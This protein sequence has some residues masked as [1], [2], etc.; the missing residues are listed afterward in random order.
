MTKRFAL[1]ALAGTLLAGAV[2]TSALAAA[3]TNTS[4]P[5]IAGTQEQGRTLTAR[6]GIWTNSPTSFSYQW[7]RCTAAGLNCIDIDGATGKTYGVRTIDVGS[8]LRVAVTATNLAGSEKQTSD[9]TDVVK[10]LSSP[11]STSATNHRPTIRIL[12]THF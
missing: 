6:N 4:Q 11:P 9:R 12:N 10:P 5:T 2:A 8:T 3:P 7:Q 1:V